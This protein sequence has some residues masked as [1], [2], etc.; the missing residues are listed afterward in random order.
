MSKKIFP[1]KFIQFKAIHQSINL[2]KCTKKK[3]KKTQTKTTKKPQNFYKITCIKQEM[4][5]DFI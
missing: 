5:C 3:E 4:K 2:R 1:Q